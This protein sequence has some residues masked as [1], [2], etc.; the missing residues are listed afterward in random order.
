[1]A[2]GRPPKTGKSPLYYRWI[3]QPP[4]A[5]RSAAQ[6]GTAE[7]NGPGTGMVVIMSEVPGK[8]VHYQ[9][10]PSEACKTAF[11]GRG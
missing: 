4:F 11:V 10:T 1:M 6:P 2:P 9:Q 5:L 8:P 7:L 3:M